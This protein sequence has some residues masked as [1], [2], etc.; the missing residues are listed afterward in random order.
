MAEG[1]GV[2][3]LTTYLISSRPGLCVINYI[4]CWDASSFTL[5][6]I[7]MMMMMTAAA[8]N[9]CLASLGR[10]NTRRIN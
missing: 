6:F 7:L 8:A 3:K 9:V 4:L 2:V 10:K 5:E 1:L